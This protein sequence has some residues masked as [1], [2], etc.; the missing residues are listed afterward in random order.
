LMP[1]CTVSPFYDPM[2]A[3]LIAQ[4][5][6]REEARR[7]LIMAL[8][9]T[10][11]LGVKTNR[12]LLIAMLRHPAFA[13]GEATTAFIDRY[14]P[15]E[16]AAVRAPQPSPRVLALAA[17]LLFE[18]RAQPVPRDANA[19]QRWSSTGAAVWPLQLTLSNAH[20]AVSVMTVSANDYLIV[21]GSDRIEV[22][23]VRRDDGVVR[24]IISGVQQSARFAVQNNALYVDIDGAVYEV[25]D[26][27]LEPA[28]SS[29]SAGSLRL[30]APMNGVIVSV[31]AKP[32]DA[33]AK[34]QCIVVL[35]AMKM[36]HEIV[37]DRDGT[38]DKVLVKLGDQVATR[39]LLA[40]LKPEQTSTPPRG[41]AA[42]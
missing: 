31:L 41:E 14:F 39:Q 29:R 17:V 40:E 27:T 2:L 30:L 18:V 28:E 20:H 42:S 37:A 11:V 34:G 3:K 12:S 16:G 7:R 21:L 9:D 36:Q 15:T 19:A 24:F 13:A 8:E 6:T 4:G 26:A 35:E 22:E 25:R 38:I 1:G 32:D 5:A 10:V 33:V 23:I